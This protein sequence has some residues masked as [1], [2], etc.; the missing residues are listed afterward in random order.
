MTFLVALGGTAGLG[1]GVPF[2][3]AESAAA[4]RSDRFFSTIALILPAGMPQR[5]GR[6]W[7]NDTASPSVR[8][9]G[10]NR[11]LNEPFRLGLIG[12]R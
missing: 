3:V 7:C 6:L 11:G 10:K 4:A 1:E 5:A 12:R 9:G 8:H 2:L